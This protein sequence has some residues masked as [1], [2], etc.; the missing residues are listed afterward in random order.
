M[1]KAVLLDI[2][3][4]LLDFDK[5]AA[6][7]LDLACKKYN[8]PFLDPYP[9]LFHKVNDM[10]WDRVEKGTLTR[11]G[12]YEIRFPLVFKE[13]GTDCADKPGFELEFRTQLATLAEKMDGAVELLDYLKGKYILCAASNCEYAQQVSRLQTA[14]ILTYFD[15]LF[16]SETIGHPKPSKAFFDYTLSALAPLGPD[17]ILMIGDSPNADIAGAK[18]VGYKTCFFAH[19]KRASIPCDPDY[20]VSTLDE[21]RSIL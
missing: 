14:G 8:V 11:N 16:F 12:L 3:D 17:E 15:K 2:D 13:W 6:L 9:A 7:A 21:I 19:G 10:L 5:N 4:T 20:R 18:T 1:I